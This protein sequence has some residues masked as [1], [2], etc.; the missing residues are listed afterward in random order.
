MRTDMA[1]G[2]CETCAHYTRH[3]IQDGEGNWRTVREGCEVL[4]YV[5]DPAVPDAGVIGECRYYAAEG[6]TELPTRGGIT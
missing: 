3:R 4:T 5:F 6:E 2:L 1:R